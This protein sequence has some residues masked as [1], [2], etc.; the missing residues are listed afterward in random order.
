MRAG[1]AMVDLRIIHSMPTLLHTPV[2]MSYY[3]RHMTSIF[4]RC[5]SPAGRMEDLAITPLQGIHH[6]FAYF[7]CRYSASQ[8]IKTGF[9]I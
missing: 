2:A 5:T 7:G 1:T 9:A 6:K 8:E 4:L 3:R